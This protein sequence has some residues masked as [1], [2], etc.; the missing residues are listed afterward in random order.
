MV[1]KYYLNFYANPGKN[2]RHAVNHCEVYKEYMNGRGLLEEPIIVIEDR[3]QDLMLKKLKP[4]TT[5]EQRATLKEY[6]M[7]WGD[8]IVILANGVRHHY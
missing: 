3:R 4:Y 1:V 6:G 7:K 8:S 2:Q 5:K